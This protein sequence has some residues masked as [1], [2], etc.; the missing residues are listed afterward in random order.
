[1]EPLRTGS[2]RERSSPKITVPGV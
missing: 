1:V 2:G